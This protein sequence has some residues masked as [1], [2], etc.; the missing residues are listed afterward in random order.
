M[1]LDEEKDDELIDPD[2]AAELDEEDIDEEEDDDFFGG[3][4]AD[5]D[6]RDWGM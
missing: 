4:A 6:D 3:A 1:A 2:L 5:S